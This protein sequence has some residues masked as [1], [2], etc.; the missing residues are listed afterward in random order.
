MSTIVKS[1]LVISVILTTFFSCS[2]NSKEDFQPVT[3]P[4]DEK[5]YTFLSEKKNLSKFASLLHYSR[6][7]S[8][9]LLSNQ[10]I[11]FVAEKV[12][13]EKI[14]YEISQ[15]TDK[16]LV[17]IKSLDEDGFVEYNK[18][19]SKIIINI[20][21]SEVTLEKGF[22]SDKLPKYQFE[23]L[24]NASVML[25]ET[26]DFELNKQTI[27]LSKNRPKT[28][29]GGVGIG[30]G[31]SLATNRSFGIA[32]QCSCGKS[33]GTDCACVVGDFLCICITWRECDCAGG[34]CG[35]VQ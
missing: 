13:G 7:S 12:E 14:N 18:L 31:K 22:D 34:Y 3:S 28:M 21:N 30:G 9:K 1:A 33:L 6:L 2:K 24:L 15:S 20:N 26:T 16:I 8:G 17:K 23:F 25:I 11:A 27:A 5:V 10:K 4:S 32:G 35:D 29:C 19:S